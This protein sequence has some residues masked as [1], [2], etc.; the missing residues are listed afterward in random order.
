MALLSSAH[1]TVGVGGVQL[2]AE[3]TPGLLSLEPELLVDVG[4]VGA[5]GLG[6][7]E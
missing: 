2:L 4:Q 5:D 3:Q 7:D 6:R 1:R